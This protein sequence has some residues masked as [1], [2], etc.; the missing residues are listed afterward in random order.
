MQKAEARNIAA[1]VKVGGSPRCTS[2]TSTSTPSCG[3]ASIPRLRMVSRM[4][5][6]LTMLALASPAVAE[7]CFREVSE[8]LH[9]VY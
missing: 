3:W 4:A 8:P 5:M 9:E 6:M 1:G 2:P 7:R